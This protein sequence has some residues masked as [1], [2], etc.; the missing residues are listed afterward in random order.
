MP[1]QSDAGSIPC[2]MPRRNPVVAPS[3]MSRLRGGQ[4][5]SGP[6][7]HGLFAAAVEP[8]SQ[9][10]RVFQYGAIQRAADLDRAACE[11]KPRRRKE[12]EAVFAAAETGTSQVVPI[13][14][15][16]D[17]PDHLAACINIETD[18]RLGMIMVLRPAGNAV[19]CD[20]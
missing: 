14:V 15:C 18:R 17:L 6:V 12:L 2:P 19:G 1:D 10:L 11:G 13:P 16:D 8:S 7:Q 9:G 3:A 4:R 5:S 20:R